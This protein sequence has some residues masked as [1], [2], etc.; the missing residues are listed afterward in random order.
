MGVWETVRVGSA[1]SGLVGNGNRWSLDNPSSSGVL[2]AEVLHKQKAGRSEGKTLLHIY[3]LS[4]T[5]VWHTID[6]SK[7]IHIIL[8][9][10]TAKQDLTD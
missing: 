6:M 7:Y 4:V 2:R 5:N 1:A 8:V 3:A 10:V 9:C